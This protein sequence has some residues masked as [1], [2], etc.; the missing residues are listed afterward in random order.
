MWA[1]KFIL[2]CLNILCSDM[3]LEKYEKYIFRIDFY[4]R[5]WYNTINL[6]KN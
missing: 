6:V 5:I 3:F 4:L 1:A 2:K